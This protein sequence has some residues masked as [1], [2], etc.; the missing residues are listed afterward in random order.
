MTPDQ[1]HKI[2]EAAFGERYLHRFA[3]ALSVHPRTVQRWISG[4]NEL[5]P[6]LPARAADVV[7]NRISELKELLSQIDLA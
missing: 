6:W 3:D 7:R 4:K 1:L 2:G 5:P